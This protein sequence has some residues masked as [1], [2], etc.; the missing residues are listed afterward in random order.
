MKSLGK[1]E[2]RDVGKITDRLM[3]D[4]FKRKIQEKDLHTE[5][6]KG[7]W[8]EARDILRDHFGKISRVMATNQDSLQTLYQIALKELEQV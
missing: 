5:R 2:V 1:E 7:T 8:A 4:L 3:V 6:L